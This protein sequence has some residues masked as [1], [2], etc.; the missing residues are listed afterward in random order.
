KVRKLD[1]DCF[2]GTALPVDMEIPDSVEEYINILPD[3]VKTMV[4]G[5]NCQNIEGWFLQSIF[6]IRFKGEVPPTIQ[7][8]KNGL[9]YHTLYVPKG[10]IQAYKEAYAMDS[11]D[12]I[13]IVSDEYWDLSKEWIAIPYTY[14]GEQGVKLIK[15]QGKHYDSL[16]FPSIYEG[17]KVLGIGSFLLQYLIYDD[18]VHM[19]N[20]FSEMKY[21]K[22][23][24]DMAF[25]GVSSMGE[26]TF[27]DALEVIGNQSFVGVIIKGR[28]TFGKQTR[29]VEPNAFHYVREVVMPPKSVSFEDVFFKDFL[30]M[31]H[32]PEKDPIQYDKLRYGDKSV[33]VVP[34]GAKAAYKSSF[35]YIGRTIIEESEYEAMDKDWLIEDE[36]IDGKKHSKIVNYMGYDSSVKVPSEVNGKKITR[37]GYGAFAYNY[38]KYIDMHDAIY[39]THIEKHAFISCAVRQLILPQNLKVVEG[40]AFYGARIDSVLVIPEGTERLESRALVGCGGLGV[41]LPSTLEYVGD[42]VFKYSDDLMQFKLV[43]LTHF[44]EDI[45]MKLAQEYVPSMMLFAPADIWEEITKDPVWSSK[46]TIYQSNPLYLGLSPMEDIVIKQGEIQNLNLHVLSGYDWTFNKECQIKFHANGFEIKEMNENSREKGVMNLN[47]KLLGKRA[48]VENGTVD[49]TYNSKTTT[50]PFKL[51]VIADPTSAIEK[52]KRM[53]KAYPT[54]FVDYVTVETIMGRGTKIQIYDILGQLHYA[55]LLDEDLTRVNLSQ[56]PQGIYIIRYESE[57]NVTSQRIVKL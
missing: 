30:T 49:F 13:S 4:V 48:V 52:D 43:E 53:F 24:D 17:E 22:S 6:S 29:E 47:F 51:T 3:H 37:L 40:E 34:D 36:I 44:T 41:S 10:A 42:E 35:Y 33:C 32:F 45:K 55:N 15:Y 21:L 9:K 39:L 16:V 14:A 18:R 46:G 31:I 19:G 8:Y 28:L 54:A 11:D 7:D 25:H 20:N 26:I 2:W 38:G 12:E 50:F 56:L 27:P 1:S 57:G 23:I 5:R